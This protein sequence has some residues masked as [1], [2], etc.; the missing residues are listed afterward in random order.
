MPARSRS[1]HSS[2]WR[3]IATLGEQIVNADSLADQ[4]DHI[5]AMTSKLIHGDIDVWLCEKVFRLPSLK[6]ENV[7]PEDPE[8]QGMQRAIKAGHVLTK[9]SRVKNTRGTIPMRE[10]W[11]VGRARGVKLADDFV[12]QRLAFAETL[13]HEMKA[14]MAHDL[15][16]GG[17]LGCLDRMAF[18]RIA[19]SDPDEAVRALAGGWLQRSSSAAPD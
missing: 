4:R 7:F 10:T 8:L 11:A 3:D 16:A 5:V 18:E 1:S 15:E 13:P 9:Q 17:R 2:D 12:E 6:E 14:S 19:A